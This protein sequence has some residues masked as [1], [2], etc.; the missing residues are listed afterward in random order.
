M[1]S[2]K[3]IAGAVEFFEAAERGELAVSTTPKAPRKRRDIEQMYL[4]S[5]AEERHTAW[6]RNFGAEADQL[7]PFVLTRPATPRAGR[8][9]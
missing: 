2:R 6:L 8:R 4:D 5:T 1:A 7:L 9:R 3:P